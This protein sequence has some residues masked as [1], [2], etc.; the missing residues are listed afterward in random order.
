RQRFWEAVRERVEGAEDLFGTEARESLE[1]SLSL[2]RMRGRLRRRALRAR[3]RRLSAQLYLAIA[4]ESGAT[5]IVD[6]SSHPLRARVLRT[7]EDVDLHLVYLVRDPQAVVVSFTRSEVA[8]FAKSALLT[9]AYISFTSLLCS[10]VF[11]SHPRERRLFV[12]YE[13]FAADPEGVIVQ[14]LRS[15]GN[16]ADAP[17][18]T[19]L[20]TGI[21]F[22]GNR[23]LREGE[24]VGFTRS[25]GPPPRRSIATTLF[26]LPWSVVLPRLRPAARASVSPPQS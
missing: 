5:H 23:L 10:L 16:P 3:Y 2:F 24:I 22:Q 14:I 17:D 18:F 11:L 26:Q 9:N 6:T 8:R 7:L 15:V 19:A 13:D 21:P 4:R 1:V 25:G 12:R 20:R